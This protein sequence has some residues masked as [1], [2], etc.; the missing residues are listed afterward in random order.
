MLDKLS[1]RPITAQD[2]AAFAAMFRQVAQM[3]A[4]ARPD[5]YAPL[6]D[7]FV[8]GEVKRLMRE[9]HT[10]ILIADLNGRAVGMCVL[11][12]R[13]APDVPVLRPRCR[14]V[15]DDLCV[16]EGWRGRGIGKRLLNAAKEEARALGAPA[17]ELMVWGFN[18]DA[19]RFYEKAGMAVQHATLE[20]RL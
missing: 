15:I 1:I 5:I 14:A 11:Q 20:M 8:E 13:R 10:T 9:E 7:A 6:T 4:A 18:E 16:L 12:L 3:H 17:L 2:E 19:M